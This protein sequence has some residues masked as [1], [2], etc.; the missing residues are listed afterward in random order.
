MADDLEA[1]QTSVGGKILKIEAN[2]I[3]HTILN[4]MEEVD[5]EIILMR[6]FEGMTNAEAAQALELSPNGA[7][8]RYSRAME[9]L[10]REFNQFPGSGHAS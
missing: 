4:A 7:S 8:S 2:E 6:T 5:R 1:S 3:L 10:T 9:R